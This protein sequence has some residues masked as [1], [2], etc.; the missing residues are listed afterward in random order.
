MKGNKNVLL[1]ML[2]FVVAIIFL[3]SS[4][5]L[6][7]GFVAKKIQSIVPT[8]TIVV[9]T[10]YQDRYLLPFLREDINEIVIYNVS[11]FVEKYNQEIRNKVLTERLIVISIEEKVPLNIVIGT[12]YVESGYD[13]NFNKNKKI[14]NNDGSVDQGPMGQ[15]SRSFPNHN[16]FD[17]EDT[18]RATIQYFR[19]LFEKYGSWEKAIIFYNCGGPAN[20][21][22][23]PLDHL[24]R[25]FNKEKEL[26]F[27][28]A[29]YYNDLRG[30]K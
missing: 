11:F 30:L 9:K 21:S 25:V 2:G 27:L 10:Q 15:N 23:K 26:N 17:L 5:W 18:L 20:L 14:R 7:S 3:T 22:I 13:V 4:L 8:N 1:V 6:G 19:W 29:Q 28:F 24:D 16:P 12:C